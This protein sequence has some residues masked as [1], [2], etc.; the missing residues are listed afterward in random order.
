MQ[1]FIIDEK[2]ELLIAENE[3]MATIFAAVRFVGQ[4][5]QAIKERGSF[6]VALSGGSTPKKLYEY[7]KHYPRAE[8]EIDWSKVNFFW[9]DERAVP[10]DHPESN[11]RMA[12]SFFNKE[13][14]DVARKFPMPAFEEDKEKAAKL[15]ETQIK[16]FCNDGR[17]DLVLLGI[18]EDGHTASLF[19]GTEALHNEKDLV[20]SLFVP[21]KNSY[22]M[23]L[24]FTCINNARKIN[25]LDN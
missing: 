9:S 8:S 1:L 3:E 19:P 11:Y 15:Y 5:S 25:L 16:K 7:L 21:E 12:M 2:R 20:C 10:L 24:T 14:F 18:G 4:A 23:T 6:S 13:P 22:R 17:F